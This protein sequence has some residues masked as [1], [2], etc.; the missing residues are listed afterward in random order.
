MGDTMKRRKLKVKNCIIAVIILLLVIYLIVSLIVRLV[1]NNHK[2]EEKK[3]DDLTMYTSEEINKYSKENNIK[4]NISYEYN[5]D[6]DKDKVISQSVKA[7]TKLTE[8]KSIDVVI[9]RGEIEKEVLKEKQVNELGKVPIMMYHGIHNVESSSTA[10]TGGN[11][12]KDGYNRTAEAFRSDL[13]KYYS[14]G[15]R[16]IRLI[17]YVNGDIDVPLGYSPIVLTFD[18]GASNNIKVTGLDSDGNIIIDPNSAVGI[19]EEFK[20]KYPDFNVT[21]TFFVTSALFNQKEYNDK[22]VKWLVEHGYDIGN[23]TE[24]HND[25]ASTTTEKTQKVIAS[26]YKKLDSLIPDK[27]VNILALPYGKPTSRTHQNYPYVLE[28]EYDGY[29]YKTLAALRV[30]WEPEVSPYNK[31]FNITYIK[32]CRA[33]DNNGKDFDIEMVFK[34]LEKNRYIS[35]GFKDVITVKEQDKQLLSDNITSKKIVTY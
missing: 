28:G 17:D 7:G 4:V 22:I 3:L 11:V 29:S 25:L 9:S 15:Y 26:V 23:H 16:M 2:E 30:G 32:R 6:I 8:V 19:L 18:D 12:D 33:Y 10:Y 31:N 34:L 20:K 24:S 5:Y 27:Y 1:S 35:D 21:A 13:E 14:L